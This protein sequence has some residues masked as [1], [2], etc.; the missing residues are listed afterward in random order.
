MAPE[1]PNDVLDVGLHGEY[2]A[3]H[4]SGDFPAFL[5]YLRTDPKFYAKTPEELLK[6]AA[7]IAKRFDNVAGQY[8]GY[9]PRQRFGIR[10]VAPD[11]APYY[12]SGRGGPGVYLLNTYDLPARPLYNMTALTLHES[13]PGHAFQIP[14][15]MEHK[16]QPAFRRDGYISAYGEGWAFYTEKL[17]RKPLL[18]LSPREGK[19]FV[20]QN[21]F[22]G[23]KIM[24][25]NEQA[26]SG[27]DLFP[28]YFKKEKIGPLVGTRTW[29]G[30]VGM[31]GFPS[32]L[33]GGAVTAPGWAWWQ[34]DDKG[35]GEWV[36]ENHGVDPDYVVEQRPDLV[37]E[38]HDPQLE[39]AI[40]LAM[41]ALKKSPPP[42]KR[43]PYPNKT[44]NK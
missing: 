10:P 7:W 14:I 12:T 32:M 36:V 28:Y 3:P 34:P 8:F 15:A 17:G 4:F 13:A 6:D 30:V 33:D 20:P 44:N 41:D 37:L 31:G 43:P 5:H 35:G 42:I 23:P 40:E 2:R 24:L 18:A 11:L 1:L 9:L 26:G 29:G 21:A 25:V 16:D 39:K 27:G 38:G 19:D 22:F